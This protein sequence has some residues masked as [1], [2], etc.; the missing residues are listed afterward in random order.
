MGNAIE[1]TKHIERTIILNGGTDK[2]NGRCKISA[3][4]RGSFK[5]VK[6]FSLGQATYQKFS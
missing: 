6:E 3:Q 1:A 4:P 5:I 2:S